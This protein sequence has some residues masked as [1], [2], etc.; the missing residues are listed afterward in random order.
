MTVRAAAACWLVG[1]ATYVI[2]EAAAASAYP[3]YRYAHDFISDLG[4]PDSPQAHLMNTA[5]VVQGGLF[6]LAAVLLTRAVDG[7]RPGVFVGLAAANAVGNVV[8]AAVP[9]GSPGT[10]WLHVGGATVAILGGNAAVLA[11]AP[12][13]SAARPYRLMSRALAGTGLLSFAALTVAAVTS[14]TVLLPS[15][16][17]ERTSVYTIIGWQMVSAAV[18][19]T[20]AQTD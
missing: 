20:S 12:F 19:L 8:V 9:S 18:L 15:A 10:A 3:D 1:G 17:W 14:T 7:R 2:L 4:R 5:F 13:L 11:G 6:G 16:V